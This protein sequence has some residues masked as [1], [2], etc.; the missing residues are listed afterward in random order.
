MALIALFAQ[1]TRS[2]NRSTLYDGDYRCQLQN[3]TAARSIGACPAPGGIRPARGEANVA[4][5]RATGS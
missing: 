1:V 5:C 4:N 3:V 2:T